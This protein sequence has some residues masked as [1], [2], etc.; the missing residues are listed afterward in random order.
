[1]VSDGTEIIK[2]KEGVSTATLESYNEKTGVSHY[3]YDNP[4]VFNPKFL[5]I[6][7]KEQMSK[8]TEEGFCK[9]S[10]WRDRGPSAWYQIYRTLDHFG[11]WDT[12]GSSSKSRSISLAH[13]SGIPSS[14]SK[15][16]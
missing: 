8:V 5:V 15:A 1:V 16:A 14:L 11:V 4:T 10:E 13:H 6:Y 3:K 7:R 9:H 12:L 2:V